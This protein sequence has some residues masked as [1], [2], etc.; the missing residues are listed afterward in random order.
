MGASFEAILNGLSATLI[1]VTGYLI[2]IRL[3]FA[4]RHSES[5]LLPYQATMAF[6]FGSFYTGTVVSFWLLIF[7][8]DNIYPRELAAILCYSITPIAIAAAMYVGFSMIKPK[9]AKP[10]A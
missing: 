8:N 2:A 10:M 9:L 6:G 4:M 1:L 3:L 7:T 5:K